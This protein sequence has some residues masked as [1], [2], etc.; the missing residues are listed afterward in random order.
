PGI[1]ARAAIGLALGRL[2]RVE[3]IDDRA[4]ETVRFRGA[5]IRMQVDGDRMDLT[6][7]PITAGKRLLKVLVP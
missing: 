7:E 4:A 3:G 1:L 6:D 2:D 5:D